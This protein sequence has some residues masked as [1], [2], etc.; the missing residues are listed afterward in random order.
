MR[1]ATVGRSI[2]SPRTEG[3]HEMTTPGEVQT[4]AREKATAANRDEFYGAR[5]F[6]SD[7]RHA[8]SD[9]RLAFLLSDDVYECVVA[10]VFGIPR[11]RQTFLAKLIV[12]SALATVLGAYAARL[13]R[14]RP[15]G[16]DIAMGG[17]ALDTALRGIAGARSQNMP[18]AGVL[19][20]LAVLGHGIRHGIRSAAARSSRDV[21]EAVHGAEAR[22]GHRPSTSVDADRTTRP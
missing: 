5:L 6:A 2:V 11:E 22:Y 3:G 21:H 7:V 18:A 17:A 9:V 1:R 14:I 16:V 20:G 8:R 19:I 13:P 15:S 10:K 4:G 12:T